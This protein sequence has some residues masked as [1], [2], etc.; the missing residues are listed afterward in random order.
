M[1]KKFEYQTPEEKK[2]DSALEERSFRRFIENEGI[3]DKDI[4]LIEDLSKS[5]PYFFT[6]AKNIFNE[7]KDKRE[8]EE[9]LDKKIKALKKKMDNI[10][11]EYQ[12]EALREKINFYKLIQE[13]YNKYDINTTKYLIQISGKR[14]NK[15][16]LQ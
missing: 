1:R 13:L 5:S 4:E 16:N 6:E 12:G 14:K 11:N 9:E 15:S 10:G 3:D 8:I 7:E 2:G